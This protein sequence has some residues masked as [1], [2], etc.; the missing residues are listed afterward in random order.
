MVF[1]V[2]YPSQLGTCDRW[3]G[4]QVLSWAELCFTHEFRSIRVNKNEAN[5]QRTWP[6]SSSAVRCSFYSSLVDLPYSDNIRRSA[7]PGSHVD[8]QSRW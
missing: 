2:M 8:F 1:M 5:R 7:G 4:W 6:G 3:S